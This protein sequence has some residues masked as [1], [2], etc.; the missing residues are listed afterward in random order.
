[1][2]GE[3]GDDSPRCAHCGLPSDGYPGPAG[4]LCQRCYARL[5]DERW[6]ERPLL[7]P[8]HLLPNSHIT[9][10]PQTSRALAEAVRCLMRVYRPACAIPPLPGRLAAAINRMARP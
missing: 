10:P 3:R 6:H 5:G 2:S 8:V 1:M 7:P 4:R 9:L